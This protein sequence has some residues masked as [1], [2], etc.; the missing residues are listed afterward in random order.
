MKWWELKPLLI[1]GAR[2]R[3]PAWGLDKRIRI[4]AGS[5]TTPT[6]AVIDVLTAGGIVTSTRVVQSADFG[7]A[8]FGATDWETIG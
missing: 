7:E 4:I 6:L 1:A 3:L 2:A 5:G 8:E